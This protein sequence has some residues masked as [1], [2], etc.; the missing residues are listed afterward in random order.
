MSGASGGA[1]VEV[2]C[3]TDIRVVDGDTIRCRAGGHETTVR[4]YGI[5]A[6]ELEQLGG[7]DA[8][9][10]LESIIRG[11]EPLLMEV[12][13]VDLYGRDVGLLY[14]RR[15]HRRDSVNI[16]MVREGNAYAF[17]R[18][19]GRELGFFRAAQHDARTARRGV[20]KGSRAG[21]ERP[22]D[23]RRRIR[24]G[25]VP[26]SLLLSLLI[27]TNVGRIVLAVLLIAL[28]TGAVLVERCG[29]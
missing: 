27:G 16:R 26:K 8:A 24:E 14:V 5:D 1:R 19:G 25:P 7:P 29:F 28:L 23:Y 9:D 10:A 3:L 4:L 6:P 21:G 12:I 11:S 17:T 13:D 2:R 15:S 20:W 18:F 22:W